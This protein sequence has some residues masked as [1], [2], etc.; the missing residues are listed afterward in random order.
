[1]FYT[2]SFYLFWVTGK[3]IFC[4]VTA[5]IKN[6]LGSKYLQ[7]TQKQTMILEIEQW[8]KWNKN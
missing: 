4:E 5:V 2:K 8:I 6:L 3:S 1:M 7:I